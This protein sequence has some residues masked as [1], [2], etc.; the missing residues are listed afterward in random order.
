MQPVEVGGWTCLEK[1][2]NQAGQARA[3]VHDNNIENP[4]SKCQSSGS[5]CTI[6]AFQIESLLRKCK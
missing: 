3:G 2:G 1:L 5:M 6:V 4:K